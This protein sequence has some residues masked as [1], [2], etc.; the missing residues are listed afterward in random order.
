MNASK[1]NYLPLLLSVEDPVVDQQHGGDRKRGHPKERKAQKPVGVGLHA[2]KKGQGHAYQKAYKG[3]YQQ[4][5]N[6]QIGERHGRS[7]KS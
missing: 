3:A 6:E 2:V 5:V 4:K 1:L 7:L